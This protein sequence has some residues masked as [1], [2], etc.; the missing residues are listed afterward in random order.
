MAL[1]ACQMTRFERILFRLALLLAGII[2][3]VRVGAIVLVAY[4]HHVR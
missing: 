1:F 3:A 2:V 4:L